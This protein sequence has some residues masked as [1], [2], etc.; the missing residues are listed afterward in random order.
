MRE[1]SQCWSAP[2]RPV[3]PYVILNFVWLSGISSLLNFHGFLTKPFS[4]VELSTTVSQALERSNLEKQLI[5]YRQIN[6]LKDDFMAII[7]HE[8]RTPLSLV[9][10]SIENSH[11][12]NS[13]IQQR[14]GDSR[15]IGEG[16]VGICLV[17]N[18]YFG[19]ASYSGG[20]NDVEQITSFWQFEQKVIP[21][22]YPR[23]KRDTY[24]VWDM[25][26]RIFF[27]PSD[28]N[29]NRL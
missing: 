2:T 26:C 29:D 5:A 11:V 8:L 6:K 18:N 22:C 13:R 7:S 4:Y 3:F 16:E 9:V 20:A 1:T 27:V 28:I 15:S 24:G 14:T 19:I 12:H 10:S 23:W 25:A 21:C 17:N